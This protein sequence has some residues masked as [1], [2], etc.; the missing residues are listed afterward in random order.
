MVIDDLIVLARSVPE[1]RKD[2]RH[3]VCVAGH[4]PTHGM[5]RLYPARH[6]APLNVWN[7]VRVEVERNPQDTRHESW[8]IVGSKND[9]ENLNTK[10]RVVGVLAKPERI[11]L[12]ER[13]VSPCVQ[14][15]NQQH[16]SLGVIRPVVHG[17]YFG[18]N[19]SYYRAHTPMFE[20]LVP[21]GL[22][23][24]RDFEMEPRIRYVCGADC[25]SQKPHDQQLLEWGCYQYIKK[26]PDRPGDIWQNL[27]ITDPQYNVYFVVG[28]QEN[29]RTSYMVIGVVRQ[30][31]RKLQSTGGNR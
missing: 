24:K 21:S 15:L 4:S 17:V 11:P 31:M 13:L 18:E 6:D 7:V 12:V 22:R 20:P 5:I 23:T 2:G 25:K 29:Q 9:W 16:N 8:K 28:N 19:R 10:I 14:T 26:N 27:H 3:T 1:V 30:K